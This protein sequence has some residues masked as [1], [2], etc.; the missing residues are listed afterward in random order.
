MAIVTGVAAGDV[1]RILARRNVA[2]VTGAASAND[3]CV[4]DPANGREYVR[5]VAVFAHCG[6]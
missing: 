3:L 2:I 5:V 6:G 4:V 1:C